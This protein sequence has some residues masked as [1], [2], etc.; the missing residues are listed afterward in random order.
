MPAPLDRRAGFP[1][2]ELRHRRTPHL[3]DPNGEPQLLIA[4]SVVE[5]RTHFSQIGIAQLPLCRRQWPSA[6]RSC[7]Y[8]M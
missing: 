5:V 2:P 3:A 6:G 1:I 8:R 7:R 4:N